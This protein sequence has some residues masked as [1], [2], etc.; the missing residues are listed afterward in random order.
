MAHPDSA[1]PRHRHTFAPE[2]PATPASPPK[3][4]WIP[5]EQ[6]STPLP[7][8]RPAPGTPSSPS[9]S[10]GHYSHSRDYSESSSLQQSPPPHKPGQSVQTKHIPSITPG[11]ELRL[12]EAPGSP[13]SI[14]PPRM[15]ILDPETASIN[16]VPVHGDAESRRSS[17]NVYTPEFGSTRMGD[18]TH[19]LPLR[20]ANK[21]SDGHAE[22]QQG[23]HHAHSP[24]SSIAYSNPTI[25]EDGEY[26]A[27]REEDLPTTPGLQ[28]HAFEDGPNKKGKKRISHMTTQSAGSSSS[29]GGEHRHSG[30]QSLGVPRTTNSRPTSSSSALG[31]EIRGRTLSPLSA[32]NSSDHGSPMRQGRELST[33]RRSPS[34]RPVSYVDLLNNVPYNQQIAPGGPLNNAGLQSVVGSAASLLDTKKTLEMYRANV[35]KTKDPSIQ[36]EF[37]IFMINA[38]SEITPEDDLDSAQ[39]NSEAKLILQSLSDRAYPFA[40]YYLG[41]GY[42]SGLFN[43]G[44]PDY[45]KAFP[46]FVAASKRGH[47]EAG[48]RAALSYEFGWGTARSMPKAVQFYRN[49]ASK[50]HPGA[51]TRLGLA[52]IKGDMGLQSKTSYR[53]GVK[54]LKRASE[55]ADFQYN[56]GPFELGLMHLTG[57]GDDIFKDE[58]YAAQLLTQSAELG[59]VD[60]NFLMGRAYEN[61]DFGCPRDAALSVHFYNGAAMKGHVEGMM[62]LCAWYMVGAEPVLEKDEAEACAWAKQAAETGW[63]KAEYAVGYFTEMG[64]G[65]RRDPLEANVWYVKAADQGNETAKQRL[66]IIR[67][68]ASGDAGIPMSKAGA[69]SKELGGDKEKKKFMGIF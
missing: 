3:H 27:Q 63:S 17:R 31:T 43:K 54:W 41:D 48:Y 22:Y 2:A 67:A 55:S 53:E 37:A 57:Y 34:N 15:G 10:N 23:S 46:L 56:A 61:G 11:P 7:P 51:A 49:S 8:M 52:C 62:A 25:Q 28:Y 14:Y 21:V 42:F 59:H 60:A 18:S 26:A 66:A 4:Q 30:S 5:K 1:P 69:K 38:A 36:Y 33:S 64:I 58:A 19:A 32:A 29:G 20:P 68:A 6:D 13:V 12:Q 44:K 9:T 35:K 24:S 47:A 45:D 39:L 65:C 16:Q 40:Q 50:N